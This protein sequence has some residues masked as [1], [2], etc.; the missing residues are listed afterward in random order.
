MTK[1]DSDEVQWK[2][3]RAEVFATI[4]DFYASNTPVIDEKA[5]E[6]EEQRKKAGQQD[7]AATEEDNETI[8]MIKEL[9]DSRIRPTVQEDGGDVIFV[10]SQ[11][12]L[13]FQNRLLLSKKKF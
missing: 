12:F 11:S 9:L 4:M 10:V 8:A 5:E 1:E 2:H 7:D 6:E 3:L 13:V